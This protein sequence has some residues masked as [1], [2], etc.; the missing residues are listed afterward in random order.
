MPRCFKHPISLVLISAGLL[1][2]AYPKF[3]LFFLAWFAFIPFFASV[4]SG[5]AGA[6]FLKGWTA[7][8][9]FFL[10]TIFWVTQ[11]TVAGWIVLA[12]YCGLYFG[13][14]AFACRAASK[15]MAPAVRCFFIP[16]FW[17]VLEFIRAH[18]V[19]GFPW[20][21]LAWSQA[22]AP[23]F[24]QV[25]DVT[26]EGGVSFFVVMA[27]VVFYEMR[28][29]AAR[30]VFKASRGALIA[31][32]FLIA[33]V[34]YGAGRLVEDPRSSCPLKVGLVQGN[35]AQEIK[36][37]ERFFD[38][39]A[40]KHRLL[41]EILELKESPDLV[42]WPETAVPGAIEVGENDA[43]LKT[44][45][46]DLGV[47]FLA[48]AIRI[49]DTRY[50]N[51]AFF[52]QPHASQPVI[53]DKLHLVPFGEYLP[54]RRTLPFLENIVPIEDF[55][56][57]ICPVLFKTAGR[58]CLSFDFSVLICFEDIFA[59][60]ARENV[61]RGADLLVNITNDG[62]FGDTASPY[63]HARASI[64]RAVENRVYVVRAANTGVTE[65]IDDAG[66][67]VAR[68]AD[69]RGKAV[70]VSGSVAADV[71]KTRRRSLYTGWGKAFDLMCLMFVAGCLALG[72]RRRDSKEE[73]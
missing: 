51:S 68:V 11:V 21:P 70:Y 3:D 67:V 58:R 30:R 5:S 63:Q 31:L 17:V 13:I 54:L 44:F 10:V 18:A 48:G 1:A 19:T 73:A 14:F 4:G 69:A 60:I 15:M 2:L 27:N 53:Y 36:W 52:Y 71:F 9:V 24:I 28:N 39:I 46:D 65:I 64:L 6:A 20:A 25:A 55:T 43:G 34:G 66:R 45:V 42:V 59:G 16:A 33:W 72:R 41:T 38:G 7:G 8:F 57:G 49:D 47:P 35:I 22:G 12:A 61:L 56:P 29:K 62:W 50:F 26:G 23:L 32:F 40:N 37:S